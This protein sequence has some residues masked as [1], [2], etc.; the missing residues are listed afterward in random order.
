[1]E[2][3]L[4]WEK[5]RI[6]MEQ[7]VCHPFVG[8]SHLLKRNNADYEHSYIRIKTAM[9][10]YHDQYAVLMQAQFD[11]KKDENSKSGDNVTALISFKTD[12]L[13]QSDKFMLPQ[14][15]M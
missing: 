9:K 5:E 3:M 4:K 11:K 14:F 12:A 7:L 2:K 8:L 15:E 6:T 10:A 13:S 1:M